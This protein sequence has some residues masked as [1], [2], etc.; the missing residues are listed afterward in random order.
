[1]RLIDADEVLK[2]WGLKF[3]A[4]G[5]DRLGS[6]GDDIMF[7]VNGLLNEIQNA[8]TVEVSD[9]D[10]GYQDGLEDGLN[11][12]RPQG[13]WEY[14]QY[15]G[16]PNIGNW[17]CSECRHIVFGG[18]SQKPYYNFCPKCGADMRGEENGTN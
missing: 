14:T 11:D 7:Y 8:P 9:Y 13:E 16:N 17:H 18:Y 5:G 10:T 15:D 2:R 4:M 12:I 6:N 3:Y 1:M